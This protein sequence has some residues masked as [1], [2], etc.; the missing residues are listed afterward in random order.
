M[1]RRCGD[2][3]LYAGIAGGAEYVIVPEIPY[4][5]KEIAK[6]ISLSQKRGKTS[7]MIV[8]AEGAGKKEEICAKINELTGVTV[9]TTTLGH[10]QRGG[11]PTA[12]DRVLAARRAV[13]LLKG[14]QGG[15]VVG[16]KNNQIIDVDIDEALKQE[17]V[18]DQKLYDI[19]HI[20]SL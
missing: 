2:I 9:K 5:I 8:L 14:G 11:S 15:R 19:A 13:D 20:L 17:R 6:S 12:A 10:I 18:F 1:G 4:D 3:A 7:N 16:I